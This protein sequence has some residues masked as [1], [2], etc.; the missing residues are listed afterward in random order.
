MMKATK[1]WVSM[2][3]L[4]ALT[5]VGCGDEAEH[6]DP[7]EHACEHV[8]EAGTAVTAAADRMSAPAITISEEPYTVTLPAG[9]AGFVK[10]TVTEDTPVL[11]F[12]KTAAVVTGLFRGETALTLPAGAPNEFCATEIP[13]HFDLDLDTPG[14]YFIQVGPSA[15][16]SVWLNLVE[17]EGHGHEHDE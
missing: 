4:S 5:A 1:R 16:T 3:I 17:A 10:V 14:D 8:G 15:T 9:V 12:A 7:A 11:L 2:A 6:E 13:E